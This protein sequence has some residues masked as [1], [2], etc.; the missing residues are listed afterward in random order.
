[1]RAVEPHANGSC[2]AKV[3]ERDGIES[4]QADD[5]GA[6]GDDRG[7]DGRVD[8]EETGKVT[9]IIRTPYRCAEQP[10]TDYSSVPWGRA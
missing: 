1:M 3:E 9:D 5:F 10:G 8:Q 7:D 2:E 6:P 4:V